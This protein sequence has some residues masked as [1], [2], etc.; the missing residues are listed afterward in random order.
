VLQFVLQHIAA[1]CGSLQCVAVCCSVFRCVVVRCSV[2]Q[3]VAGCGRVLYCNAGCC[4]VWQCVA[5][6]VSVCCSLWQSVV[7]CGSVL[8][9]VAVCC[10]VLQCL[11]FVLQCVRVPQLV[12]G[13][14]ASVVKYINI[15][16]KIRT[17][18]ECI[19]FHAYISISY[20]C[21]FT[22]MYM[23]LFTLPFSISKNTRSH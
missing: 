11:R 21:F 19:F 12:M 4:D 2:L 15:I 17:Y 20:L 10:I 7:V 16:V 3:C 14:A 1:W 23:A 5:V 22:Y 6:C 18:D 9:C 8:R 13:H